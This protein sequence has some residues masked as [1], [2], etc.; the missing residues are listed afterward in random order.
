MVGDAWVMDDVS[1]SFRGKFMILTV[2]M[3]FVHRGRF[4]FSVSWPA[5][6]AE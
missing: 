6:R 3:L 5:G 1:P 2:L 4:S